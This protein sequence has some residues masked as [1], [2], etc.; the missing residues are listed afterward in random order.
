MTGMTASH[1]AAAFSSRMVLAALAEIKGISQPTIH[2]SWFL[3]KARAA[4]MPDNGPLP[5]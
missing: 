5:G 4:C 2:T 3:D 1:F